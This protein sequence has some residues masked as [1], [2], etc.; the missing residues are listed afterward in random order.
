[1]TDN[2]PWRLSVH[3]RAG[4]EALTNHVLSHKGDSLPFHALNS[5]PSACLLGDP[6]AISRDARLPNRGLIVCTESLQEVPVFEVSL[7]Q[8]TL[9]E[10]HLLILFLEWIVATHPEV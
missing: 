6:D 8:S 1:M 10:R 7:L 2:D 9:Q 4:K 3:T 5:F